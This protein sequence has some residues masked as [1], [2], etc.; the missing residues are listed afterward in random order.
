MQ[1]KPKQYLYHKVPNDMRKNEEGRSVIYPLNTIKEKFPDLYEVMLEKY[2]ESQG[3]DEKRYE[4]R[5]TIP[6]RLIPVLENSTWGDA[7]NLSPIHPQEL[8]NTLEAEGFSP[9]E[10]KFYQIDPELL[11][12]KLTTVY[13]YREEAGEK[14]DP[15]QYE[16]FIPEKLSEHSSVPEKTKE[17]YKQR[18]EEGK[19]P[20]L[21]VGVPHILHTGHI[22]VTDIEKFPVI[23]AVPFS[24]KVENA[25]KLILTNDEYV[26]HEYNKSEVDPRSYV[27][28]IEKGNKKITYFGSSHIN[29]IEDPLFG[30]IRESFNETKPQIVYVEGM[31]SINKRKEEVKSFLNTL[32]LEDVVEKYGESGFAL[33]LAIDNNLDFESPEPDFNIEIEKILEKGYS[34]KDIFN[35]YAYR[36]VYQYQRMNDKRNVEDLAIYLKPHFDKF[37]NSSG[38]DNTEIESFIQELFSNIELDSEKYSSETDPIMRNKEEFKVTNEISKVSSDFRNEYIV[39]R[40][41]EG[42]KNH[43]R[44]FVVYGASHAVVQEPAIR[45]LLE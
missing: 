2:Q 28:D 25:K 21:F 16:E 26:E 34:K 1:E 18:F 7:I 9:K 17:Y 45:F 37:K 6:E 19:R 13:L 30:K 3:D 23:T 15:K 41:A 35:F 40:I 20:L 43:D 14:E 27:F 44:I 29:K 39:E 36:D 5:K 11:N 31:N 38:W 22:D 32:S 12:P 33:N 8:M 10:M 42:L 24:K 4:L